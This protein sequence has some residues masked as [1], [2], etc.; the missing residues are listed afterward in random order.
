MVMRRL[1]PIVV[2][3]VLAVPV[4]AQAA[5]AAQ[6]ENLWATVN[7]C[8]APGARNVIGLRGSMPAGSAKQRVY[9]HF[10]AEWYSASKK[11]WMAT[12]AS[13]PW[14]RLGNA[15]FLSVQGGYSFQ[16]ADPPSGTRFLMRGVVRY[17]WRTQRGKSREWAVARRARRVTKAGYKGV[18]GGTPT[19]RS[20]A[21]CVISH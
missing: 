14:I 2:L 7:V 10:S 17:Q 5:Q 19:G 8:D 12:G 4:T 20:D 18:I 21:L 13:S 16:F 15:G 1:L 9:M 3:A 11:R 6:A